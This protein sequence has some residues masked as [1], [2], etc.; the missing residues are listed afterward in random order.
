MTGQ[1]QMLVPISQQ[2]VQFTCWFRLQH[3]S[4][5][6]LPEEDRKD[7]YYGHRKLVVAHNNPVGCFNYPDGSG[8][9]GE[10]VTSGPLENSTRPLPSRKRKVLKHLG[11]PPLNTLLKQGWGLE[12]V[13]RPSATCRLGRPRAD[14][15]LDC[16]PP[17]DKGSPCH[18]IP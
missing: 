13:D 11:T 2:V 12:S 8:F 5:S 10:E 7:V 3:G 16:W 4:W 1:T 14:T 6:R 17:T 18:L 9:E 15:Y